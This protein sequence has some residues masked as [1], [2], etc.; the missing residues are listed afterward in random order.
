MCL[1]VCV[2]LCGNAQMCAYW[3][4]LCVFALMAKGF[5]WCTMALKFGTSPKSHHVDNAGFSPLCTEIFTGYPTA[6]STYRL[7]FLWIVMWPS[8]QEV[9]V[10]YICHK[11]LDLPEWAEWA[12]GRKKWLLLNDHTFLG[13][14]GSA[15]LVGSQ[16]RRR[17]APVSNP[18]VPDVLD[19]L[20]V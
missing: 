11:I 7:N 4:Y 16:S 3:A 6:N 5:K 10:T 8:C 12:H 13:R 2:C 14:L 19:S 1:C 17:T 20:D 9:Q 15:A 18:W